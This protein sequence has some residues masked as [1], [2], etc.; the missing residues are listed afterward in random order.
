M[1]FKLGKEVNVDVAVDIDVEGF[2]KWLCESIR[3]ASIKGKE[4]RKQN[5]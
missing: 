4:Q 5:A 3:Q 2:I 1:K